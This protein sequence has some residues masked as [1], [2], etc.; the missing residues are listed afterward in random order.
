M[1]GRPR[2]APCRLLGSTLVLF[3]WQVLSGA[4]DRLFENA[5]VVPRVLL[6]LVAFGVGLLP[7]ELAIGRLW[8]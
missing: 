5:P 8:G 3:A 4:P 2:A 6:G 7:L 1:S